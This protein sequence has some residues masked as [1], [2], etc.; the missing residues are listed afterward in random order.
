MGAALAERLVAGGHDVCG[1]DLDPG[2]RAQLA[3]AGGRAAESAEEACA[4]ADAVVLCL[5]DARAVRA[6]TEQVLAHGAVPELWID[7]TSSLPA[8]T[9]ELGGRLA[10]AGAALVDA[11]VTGGVAGAR[12]GAL[13][14]MVGGDAGARERARPLLECFAARVLPAGSLGAGHAV[15]AINN[16]LSSAS[17]IATAEVTAGRPLETTVEQINANLARSQNSEVKYVRE[18][19]TGRYGSGFTVGL[20]GKDVATACALSEDVPL[21]LITLLRA[22]WRIAEAELGPTED[23]TCIHQLAERWSAPRTSDAD[24]LPAL[25][26]V[27]AAAAREALML[28]ASLGLDREAALAI[29]NTGSGRSEFTR[30]AADPRPSGLTTGAAL[31]ALDGLLS[32]HNSAAPFCRVAA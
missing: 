14:A 18:V 32:A 17:L 5:P 20:M 2:A 1:F 29:I 9:R 22:L 15:K 30:L 3:D 4:G 31:E 6:V 19:V 21:P 11:P 27:L 23:F 13:T 24:P 25:A 26:G 28:I 16:A 12:D 7:C 8:V 10:E